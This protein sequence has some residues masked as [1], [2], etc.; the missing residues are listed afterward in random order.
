M[1]L[2]MLGDGYFSNLLVEGYGR[3]KQFDYHAYQQDPRPKVLQLARY[4]HRGTGRR[5]LAGINLNYLE[6]SQLVNL[7]KVAHLV[8]KQPQNMRYAAGVRLLPDIFKNYYRTY[9]ETFAHRVTLKTLRFMATAAMERK[10]RQAALKGWQ[11]RRSQQKLAQAKKAPVEPEPPRKL[12]ARAELS[13]PEKDMKA[14]RERQARERQMARKEVKPEIE[15]D[16]EKA[17]AEIEKQPEKRKPTIEPPEEPRAETPEE[18]AEDK[19]QERKRKKQER[20]QEREAKRLEK[21]P[22][23]PEKWVKEEP[24]EEYD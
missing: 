6:P 16:I 3:V 8:L 23:I 17:E 11:T 14:E 12:P 18:E 24:G 21:E 13:K 22:E 19:R 20:E 4:R 5:H 10:R 9:D 15:L 2:G 1:R 7:T